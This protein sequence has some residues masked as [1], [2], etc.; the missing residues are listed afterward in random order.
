MKMCHLRVVEEERWVYMQMKKL[1]VSTLYYLYVHIQHN[2][3]YTV[4][5]SLFYDLWSNKCLYVNYIRLTPTCEQK[6]YPKPEAVFIS[7][8]VHGATAICPACCCNM[9]GTQGRMNHVPQT[10]KWK[11]AEQCG[12]QQSRKKHDLWASIVY[13]VLRPNIVHQLWE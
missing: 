5:G 8:Q 1:F 4:T 9:I 12:Y 11:A 10:S 13:C 2:K 3:V 7:N 6:S